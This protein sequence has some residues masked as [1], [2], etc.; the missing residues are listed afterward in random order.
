MLQKNKDYL[1]L[2][3]DCKINGQ[4][5]TA[6]Q[7]LKLNENW[8]EIN[9]FQITSFSELERY[10]SNFNSIIKDKEIKSINPLKNFIDGEL[11]TINDSLRRLLQDSVRNACIRKRG[12][13]NDFEPEPTFVI[14]LRCFVG[15]LANQWSRS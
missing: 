1:F 14:T 5:F 10:I 2:G 8:E 15:V 7:Q 12:P 11:L 9:D 3:E 13:I 6:D 4:I